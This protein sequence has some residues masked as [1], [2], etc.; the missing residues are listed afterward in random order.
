M[1]KTESLYLFTPGIVDAYYDNPELWHI[2]ILNMLQKP[3]NT[4]LRRK[5]SS[6]HLFRSRRTLENTLYETKNNILE[7]LRKKIVKKLII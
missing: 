1:M 4:L 3:L 7:S 2:E 6:C 5:S